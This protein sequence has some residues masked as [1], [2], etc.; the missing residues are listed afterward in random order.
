MIGNK[1]D[2]VLI[3]HSV[4]LHLLDLMNGHGAGDIVSEYK[5]KLG[6]DQVACLNGFFPGC[7][8]QDLLCH[9]HSHNLKSS[10]LIA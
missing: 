2:L 1:S 8:C 3:K 7:S 6:H 10:F 5:V 9:C 4:N